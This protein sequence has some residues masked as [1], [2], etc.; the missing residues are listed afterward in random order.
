M[1]M[2]AGA[3][4]TTSGLGKT[5]AM[6]SP[7]TWPALDDA[8][9]RA[10]GATPRR[11]LCTG[12]ALRSCARATA[13][14]EAPGSSH[15]A[16]TQALSSAAWRR[17]GALLI[18]MVSTSNIVDTMLVAIHR[19]SRWDCWPLTAQAKKAP[20][21]RLL[22]RVSA[23]FV[24]VVIA[25]AMAT[26]LGW[27]L[28]TG[29]WE[30]AILIAVAVLVITCPCA[31]GLAAPTAITVGTSA[32]AK[33]GILIKDAEA[34]EVAHSVTVLAFDKTGTLTD[35]KQELM[36]AVPPQ[37]PRARTGRHCWPRALRCRLAASIRWLPP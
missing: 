9:G 29:D 20:I 4:K 5:N 16:S 21:Q 1:R 35:G 22:D 11:Y 34:L 32:A 25:I 26:V 27:G 33:R 6:N 14:T 2:S 12:F 15:A 10:A 18:C 23:G 3:A 28:T 19:P 24:P 17:R 7:A 13:A 8:G 37:Q 31:L 36:A 30:S